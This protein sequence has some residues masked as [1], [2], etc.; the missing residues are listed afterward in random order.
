[1]GLKIQVLLKDRHNHVVGINQTTE[2]LTI[3]RQ[4]Q[5]GYY[6]NNSSDNTLT[7]H[8][9]Q[10]DFERYRNSYHVL[11]VFPISGEPRKICVD[12]LVGNI[13]V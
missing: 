3:C 5:N 9:R 6:N 13:H 4:T 12:E 8:T 2:V 10:C 11:E 1:M 7:K